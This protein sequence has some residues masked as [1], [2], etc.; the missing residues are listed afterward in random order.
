MSLTLTLV[1]FFKVR[2]LVKKQTVVDIG[3]GAL[4]RFLNIFLNILQDC[5]CFSFR[6]F[7]VP[8]KQSLKE[9]YISWLVVGWLVSLFMEQTM[10]AVFD[11]LLWNL[12]CLTNIQ[13]RSS[14]YIFHT[15]WFTFCRIMCLLTYVCVTRVFIACSSSL[16]AGFERLFHCY[17]IVM[18]LYRLPLMDLL[19]FTKDRLCFICPKGINNQTIVSLCL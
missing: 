8:M 16:N 13:Q 18:E 5:F 15:A 6:I 1:I 12:A 10:S 17:C 9:S 7:F 11:K 2:L 14:W 19:A 4:Y 3:F